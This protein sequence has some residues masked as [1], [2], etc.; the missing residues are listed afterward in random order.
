M[1]LIEARGDRRTLFNANMF[2]ILPA[3][4]CCREKDQQWITDSKTMANWFSPD[5]VFVICGGP[6]YTK[7]SRSLGWSAKK[8]RRTICCTNVGFFFC[9]FCW[10]PLFEIMN[11]N[12]RTIVQTPYRPQHKMF[13]YMCVSIYWT[14]TPT[15][16]PKWFNRIPSSA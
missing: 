6:V 5:F 11:N 10:G 14:P 4:W 8:R 15:S 12:Y 13:L 16:P 1:L 2:T 3:S 9:L 7:L